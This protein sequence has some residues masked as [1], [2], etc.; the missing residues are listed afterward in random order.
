MDHSAY[1]KRHSI[2]TSLHCVI[3]DWIENVNDGAITGACLLDVSKSFDSINHTILLQKLE[4]HGAW[5]H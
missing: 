5:Y 2:Q 4:M 3:D 1:V